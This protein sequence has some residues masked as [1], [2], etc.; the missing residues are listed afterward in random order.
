MFN[1]PKIILASSLL[2][3]VPACSSEL[4]EENQELLDARIADEAKPTNLIAVLQANPD[5]STASTLL[6][7][8]GVGAELDGDGSYTAFAASNEVYNKMDSE[9]LS[10]LMHADNKDALADITK[11]SLVEGSMTSADIAKAITDGGGTASITTLQ[12]GVIKASME[13]DKIV[14]EDGAGNKINITQA[15]VE[16]TN[17]TL[18]VIDAI[19]MPK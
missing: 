5:L 8:S 15:D 13:G 18:H 16:S 11:Y 12:G 14:L 19:L 6:G 1:A 10:E 17:G 7:L 2:A 4:S 9:K 3:L